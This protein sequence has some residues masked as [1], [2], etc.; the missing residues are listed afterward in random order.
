[1]NGSSGSTHLIADIFGYYTGG[2]AITNGAFGAVSAERLLD[3]RNRIEGAVPAHG[4]VN[5]RVTGPV[6]SGVSAV[7]LNVTATESTKEGFITVHA[8][9]T[10]PGVS[11]LNFLAGQ[12]VPN[13]VI[14]PVDAVTGE[15]T[16]FNGSAGSTHLIADISGYY[17]GS[18]ADLTP[19]GPATGATAVPVS[20]SDT[21]IALSWTNPG[22]IDFDVVEIRRLEGATPPATI[23]DGDVVG[24][25]TDT[26]ATDTGLLPGMQYS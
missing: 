1:M 17:L 19:P 7:V 6:P 26:T 12:S 10:L 25:D 3:T 9:A 16:L 15:V 24:L 2:A 21:S 5:L 22:D 18:D 8:G 11:N 20:G 14:A 13:L 4:T 23:D